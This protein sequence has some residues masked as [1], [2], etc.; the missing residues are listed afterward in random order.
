MP[1]AVAFPVTELID[2]KIY[3]IGGSDTLSPM[4]SPSRIMMV[5]DTDTEM[6]QLRARPDWEAG[7]KMV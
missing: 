4:K 1:K 6:W 3:V 2:R 7:K 5:Y